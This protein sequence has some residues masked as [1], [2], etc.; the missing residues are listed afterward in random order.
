MLKLSVD[1]M[2]LE[3]V[4]IIVPSAVDRGIPMTTLSCLEGGRGERSVWPLVQLQGAGFMA[5]PMS[6][7]GHTVVSSRSDGE[8]YISSVFLWWN[9]LGTSLVTGSL[10]FTTPI[11]GGIVLR[12]SRVLADFLLWAADSVSRTTLDQLVLCMAT[13]NGRPE[14]N[15]P[16][17]D[18]PVWVHVPW[19]SRGGRDPRLSRTL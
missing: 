9:L 11:R 16:G 5:P 3:V 8:L 2:D 13:G 1:P 15:R 19:S 17:G 4:I 12:L 6:V 10:L 7:L 14:A 18:L